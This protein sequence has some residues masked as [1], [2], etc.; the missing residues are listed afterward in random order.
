MVAKDA[1][2]SLSLSC[3]AVFLALLLLGLPLLLY[4]SLLCSVAS[5]DFIEA[6]DAGCNAD[7]AVV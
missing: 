4:F 5:L 2:Q 7:V 1:W 6:V 3:P